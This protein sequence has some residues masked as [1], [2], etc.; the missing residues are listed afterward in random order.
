MFRSTSSTE[1][2]NALVEV[3]RSLKGLS[4]FP[5]S[6]LLIAE[7]RSP[8]RRAIRSESWRC[9]F[10]GPLKTTIIVIFLE[11]TIYYSLTSSFFQIQIRKF[12]NLYIETISGNLSE[13]YRKTLFFAKR[14]RYGLVTP[15]T[16][17]ISH[18]QTLIPKFC[19]YNHSCL[20]GSC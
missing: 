2:A 9:V 4:F 6:R 20:T 15:T 8:R 3:Q 14:L 12:F 13:I 18:S 11:I 7:S 17:L 10:C 5:S 1:S 19:P 16:S